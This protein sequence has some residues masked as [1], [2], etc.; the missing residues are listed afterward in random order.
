MTSQAYWH[1]DSEK[2]HTTPKVVFLL[3]P[4]SGEGHLDAYARMYSAT[5]LRLGYQVVLVADDAMCFSYLKENNIPLDNFS[6]VGSASRTDRGETIVKKI[7]RNY[8]VDGFGGLCKITLTYVKYRLT[9]P[10]LRIIRKAGTLLDPYPKLKAR[11]RSLLRLNNTNGLCAISSS[12]LLQRIQ[13][14]EKKTGLTPDLVFILYSDMLDQSRDAWSSW[15]YQWACIRFSPTIGPWAPTNTVEGFFTVSSFSGACMLDDSCTALYQ[16]IR[17]QV[18]FI[19]VPDICDASVSASGLPRVDDLR[20]RSAG[21]TVV[22]AGGGLTGRK[23]IGDLAKVIA[24]SDPDRFFFLIVG[25]IYWSTFTK[26][27]AAQLKALIKTPPENTMVHPDFLVDEREFNALIKA[28]DIIYAVYRDFLYSSN[29]LGKAAHFERPILV[30]DR[31]LMGQRVKAY[32][33]GLTVTEGDIFKIVEKL[34]ELRHFDVTESARSYRE[35]HSLANLERA[36]GNFLR[37]CTNTNQ[38]SM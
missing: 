16:K 1:K 23:G 33:L 6:I 30:S 9:R 24:S 10:F 20:K 11:I 3:N 31:H 22:F 27:D 38:K 36:L 32:G 5:I 13:W 7:V 28:S 12:N 34:E 14:A 29:M 4:I 21:R 25:R 35:D 17:P 37:T 2:T 15:P 26:V 18:P 8:R 19:T